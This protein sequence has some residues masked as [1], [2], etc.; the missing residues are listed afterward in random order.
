MS[1]GSDIAAE[2]AASLAAEGLA[3]R[4][5]LIVAGATTGPS[6]APIAG[7]SV[8]HDMICRPT[9]G[10]GYTQR[11]GTTIE[12]GERAFTVYN[13]TGIAPNTADRARIYGEADDWAVVAVD[14]ADFDETPYAWLVKLAK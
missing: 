7:P 2:V 9:D 4:F 5:T 1:T 13:T 10:A 12:A 14:P 8:E 3:N 11:T 6:Y